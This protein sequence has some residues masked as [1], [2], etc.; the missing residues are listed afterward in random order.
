MIK[1]KIHV[2]MSDLALSTD[3]NVYK[4]NFKNDDFANLFEE[5][6]ANVYNFVLNSGKFKTSLNSKEEEDFKS[7]CRDYT[8]INHTTTYLSFSSLLH[9]IAIIQFIP[10]IL[11]SNRVI[12]ITTEKH[13]ADSILNNFIKTK[14]RTLPC[15]SNGSKLYDQNKQQPKPSFGDGV[16]T[17]FNHLP[18]MDHINLTICYTYSNLEIVRKICEWEFYKTMFDTV[19]LHDF[20]NFTKQDQTKLETFFKNKTIVKVD[21]EH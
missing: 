3:Y 6:G 20:N 14:N 7:W 10:Y 21:I 4:E 2:K 5:T 19:I 13:N 17:K 9:S 11:R 16:V 18:L 15:N 1:K 8:K 12:I